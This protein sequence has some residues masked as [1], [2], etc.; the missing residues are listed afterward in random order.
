MAPY[1]APSYSHCP[2]TVR[3]RTPGTRWRRS[4]PGPRC[5][6]RG[7]AAS[8]RPRRHR[9][10]GGSRSVAARPLTGSIDE[11]VLD[12]QPPRRG[13]PGRLE[14]HRPGHVTSLVWDVGRA[15]S[16]PEVPAVRSSRAPKTLGESGRGRHSHST[17]AGGR[18]QAAVLAV[19][20]EGVVRD[21]GKGFE[22]DFLGGV[23][24]RADAMPPFCAAGVSER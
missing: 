6:W 8:R 4:R 10:L 23:G 1:P 3:T 16:E 13:V 21:G 24:H 14:D 15:R 5:S 17:A 18:D 19:R 11:Q 9:A 12:D 7:A 2:W 20:D 22:A